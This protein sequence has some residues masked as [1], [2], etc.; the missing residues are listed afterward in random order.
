MTPADDR[1]RRGRGA[2]A[3]LLHRY[4][5][6]EWPLATALLVAVLAAITAEAISPLLVAAFIDAVA[7]AGTVSHLRDLAIAYLIATGAFQ[8]FQV[9]QSYLAERLAQNTTTTLRADLTAH[10]LGLDLAFHARHRSGELVERIEGDVTALGKFLSVMV[11]IVIGNVLLLVVVLVILLVAVWPVGLVMAGFLVFACLALIRLRGRAKPLWT[12]SM[13]AD[14]DQSGFIGEHLAAAED[15]RSAGAIRY[16]LNG[17]DAIGRTLLQLRRRAA[18]RTVMTERVIEMLFSFGTGA[19]LAM[20]AWLV[21]RH[22]A[23]VGVIY[24]IY[25][26]AD[27]LSTPVY[28][29][30]RQ[31]SSFQKAAAAVTRVTELL[32]TRSA[33]IDGTAHPGRTATIPVEFDRVTFGYTPDRPVLRDVSFTVQAGERVAIVGRTGSG[34]TTIGRLLFRFADPDAGGI[35]LGGVPLTD[36]VIAEVRNRVGFVP[37]DVQI[38]HATVRDNLTFFDTSVTDERI[39]S[40]LTELGLGEWLASLPDGLS[41]VL[42]GGDGGLSAGHAQLLALSRVFLRD[43]QVVVLDEATSRLDPATER[44]VDHAIGRLLDGRSALVIAHRLATVQR[45]D[46]VVYLDAG[47]VVEQGDRGRLAADPASRFAGLLRAGLE[48]VTT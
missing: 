44:T 11:A 31:F 10:C 29:V 18:V 23:P 26:Y 48:Q 6:P 25:R 3:S 40:V 43:P 24:L 30:N 4:L 36:M 21:V 28:R 37:Q 1:T 34:K 7:G 9:M 27:L 35:R 39:T 32:G 5:I 41:T 12:E 46:R 15:I 8:V 16:T 38:I 20:G 45:V 47:Q 13:Q 17:F 22:S 14:S 2:G 42:P 19:G 33:L